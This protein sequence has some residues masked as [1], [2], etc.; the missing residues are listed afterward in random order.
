MTQ[1]A[2]PFPAGPDISAYIPSAEVEQ[3]LA[4][5]AAKLEEAPCWAGVCGPPGVGKTLL[6]RLL[7]RRLAGAFRTVYVPSARFTPEELERWVVSQP[8]ASGAAP[9]LRGG[10]RA[11]RVRP[12]L[13]ALDE[14]Q[15][16]S[17]ALIERVE[18]LCC[19]PVAARAVLAWNEAERSALP[20]ALSRCATRVFVEPLAL[21]QVP[22]YVAAHLARVGASADQCA[23]LSGTTLERIALASGGNQR[24]IQRLADAELAARA[25]RSRGSVPLL[26]RAA[27]AAPRATSSA[28]R[29]AAA[30]PGSPR[31]RARGLG[32][33]L[34]AIA[35]AVARVIAALR[36]VRP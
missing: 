29:S 3:N 9:E 17:N 5:L 22:A 7:M 19:A 11:R 35:A 26:V 12:L 25:W 27:A 13:I 28:P 33:V 20:A 15:L 32:A 30:L 34:A 14:A 18:A 6:L 2:T 24:A 4:Y 36:S 16:A 10:P 21:A 23:A 8:G 31:T 1:P